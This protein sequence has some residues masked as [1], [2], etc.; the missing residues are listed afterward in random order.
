M[1]GR[2]SLFLR[3]A[4]VPGR[5]ASPPVATAREAAMEC[6]TRGLL[7]WAWDCLGRTKGGSAA[8]KG[9]LPGAS[10]RGRRHSAHGQGLRGG[11][12][13]ARC[14]GRRGF[15]LLELLLALA[16][17]VALLG[18]IGLAVGVQLR[19]TDTGRSDVAQAQL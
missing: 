4:V 16:L 17:L 15:T 18:A 8:V 1:P 6:D 7:L 11:M 2:T 14:A 13:R 3:A 9:D 10:S 12:I 5:G 19:A